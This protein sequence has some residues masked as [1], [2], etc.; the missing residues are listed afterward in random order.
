MIAPKDDRVFYGVAVVA[1]AD[2]DDAEA[3]PFVQLPRRLVRSPHLERGLCCACACTVLQ[4]ALQQRRRHAASTV[5]WRHSE[6]VDVQLVGNTPDRTE[7]GE[8]PI[9]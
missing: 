2:A 5:G 3:E 6:I 4:H 1:A 7:A 9:V 8:A